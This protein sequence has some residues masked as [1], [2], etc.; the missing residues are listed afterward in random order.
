LADN[1]KKL[2][3]TIKSQNKDLFSFMKLVPNRKKRIQKASSEPIKSDPIN[4][5]ARK[6]HPERQYLIIDQIKDETKTSKTFKL[7]LDPDS[8][9]KELAYFRA[10]QYLSLKVKV[11]GVLITRPY[12]I[13]SSPSDALK[14]FYE[15]TIRKEEHGFLTNYIWD[16]WKVGTKI[17]SSGPEGFFY[18]EPLR[19]AKNIVAIGG[20]SG[21][22]PF[23]SMA[24]A[25]I[26]GILDANILILYG[27][28][29]EEDIIYYEELKDL[30]RKNPDKVKV[31]YVLSCDELTL[32]G[33]EQGFI[34]ADIIKKYADVNNS[35]FF[36]CGPQ[37]MYNFLDKELEEFNLPPKK[38]R[39][40]AFGEIKD[41]INL[42]NYPQELAEKTFNLKVHMEDITKEI[43]ALAT[44]SVL[45][46][47]ERANLA[48][49]SKCRSGE[50]GFCRSLLIS[51][52]VFISPIGDG[53][54]EADKKFNFFHP[55]YSYPISDLEIDIPK[56]T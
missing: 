30:E 41:I 31:V 10:G 50:C 24:N 37:I 45:V 16:N 34:T 21:I 52:E 2:T 46:A 39:K 4:E 43:P 11:N 19:D 3:I 26:E 6:L 14:D 56:D 8:D 23:R 33:C 42:P 53:R 49:P 48:P 28:S 32:E 29:D 27:S 20:G 36:I 35:S 1:E 38:I 12:S 54:R 9:T 18:Y 51:G 55:C 15:I 47:M 44:E 5:L 17:V 7:I 40:E 25:I 13:S 22:T